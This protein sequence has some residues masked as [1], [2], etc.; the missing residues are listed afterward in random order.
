M[1]E[2]ILN[3]VIMCSKS[4]PLK[5][6]HTNNKQKDRQSAHTKYQQKTLKQNKTV[7]IFTKYR[8]HDIYTHVV[9]AADNNVLVLLLCL[10]GTHKFVFGYAWTTVGGEHPVVLGH[11][12]GLVLLT[13]TAA[14]QAKV[15]SVVG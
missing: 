6:K 9:L 10:G 14:V 15:T 7:R 3:I 1:N 4:K 13:V 2:R 8:L 12:Q 5:K 11:T